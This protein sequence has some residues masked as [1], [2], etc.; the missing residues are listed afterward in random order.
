MILADNQI[1]G[2]CDQRFS[3]VREAFAVNFSKRGEVGA[4][5]AVYLAGEPV[6]DIWAGYA[7]KDQSRPWQRDTIATVA[8]T[9]KGM[10]AIC[11]HILVERGLLDL[12]RPVAHY[13]PE[14]AQAGKAEIPVRWLLSHRA[15]L[16]GVRQDMPTESLYDWER[17]TTALAEAEPWWEPGTKHGYHAL[18]YGYL[19][20]EVVRRVSGQSIGQFFRA[21]VAEPLKA[22]VYIGV[23]E[24]EDH[25]AAEII[26]DPAP[27]AAGPVPQIDPTS[28]FGRAFGNP[29]RTP[30]IMNT[31]P[32]RAAEI[33]STNGNM[34]AWGLARIYGALAMGGTLGGVRILRPET[35]DNAIVEQSS[36][37]EAVMGMPMR[38][39]L[40]F[41]LTQPVRP[42]G[43]NP[44]AF[45]HAGM[46]GSIG[47]AD[48]DAGIGF[49]YVL[50]QFKSGTPDSPDNRWWALSQALYE[51][52]GKAGTKA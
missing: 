43:P 41:G 47:F 50:N 45:G 2:E 40:G 21:E 51:N 23:P 20:G 22:D 18:T 49:G 17:Y 48:L 29:A 6:V 44:R 19:V 16:P 3:G 5:V 36:G 11:A 52:M 25:R 10:A 34:T 39:A 8:S 33:P 46:G 15:G 28:M 4:A 35:I 27:P 14:F 1:H 38:F 31:R 12:D 7:D 9:T 24:S 37:Q 42:Y 13:W 32:F 26:P 30:K